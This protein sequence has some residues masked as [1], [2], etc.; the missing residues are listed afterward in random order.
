MLLMQGLQSRTQDLHVAVSNYEV[1]CQQNALRHNLWISFGQRLSSAGR[2]QNDRD[3]RSAASAFTQLAPRCPGQQAGQLTVWCGG[4]Q[5]YNESVF[6]L[7]RAEPAPLGGRP[8][9]R[10]K[11]DAQGRV[12]VD[13][14]QEASLT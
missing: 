13:G 3:S 12:F 9:L 11:E 1:R 6:D 8:A 5:I 4:V 2:L 14:A 7:L 10:L